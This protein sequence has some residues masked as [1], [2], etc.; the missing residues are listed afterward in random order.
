MRKPD[1]DL[2]LTIDEQVLCQM[3]E[4]TGKVHVRIDRLGKYFVPY[5]FFSE[6]DDD[7][8]E[9]CGVIVRNNYMLGAETMED[10]LSVLRN[11][12]GDISAE[13][14]NTIPRPD[15]NPVVLEMRH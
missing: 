1:M 2:M 14:I 12:A 6:T 4:G 7:E 8:I 13:Y 10:V 15:S 11:I 3:L 5:I 9:P